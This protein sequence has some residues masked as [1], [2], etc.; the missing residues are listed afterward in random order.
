[1]YL[2]LLVADLGSDR[3]SRI[4]FCVLIG[5]SALTM[6][7]PS[8]GEFTK[9]GAAADD[10]LRM[11]ER[12]PLIDSTSPEGLKR[13][14]IDGELELNNLTFTYPARPTIEVLKNI[15]LK[16]QANKVTALVGASG[17]GKSTIVAMLERWYD[18]VNGQV[19]FDGEDV[20]NLNVKWYRSQ[21]GL[22]QQVTSY[23]NLSQA[24]N[25]H[26]LIER[27]PRRS[28]S[29]SMTPFTT[30]LFMVCTEVTW[31]ASTRKRRGN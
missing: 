3:L 28:Q 9:A 31:R 13:E 4:L 15:S 14:R 22:V 21:I 12:E 10:V 11:I 16:F 29:C 5:T 25:E 18:P 23:N 1:M 17:S 27:L 30:M 24:R 20:K 19:L 26:I 2:R 8:V 7:A 6:I